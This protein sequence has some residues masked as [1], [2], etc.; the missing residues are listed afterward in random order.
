MNEISKKFDEEQI[1][2]FKNIIDTK[3]DNLI[4]FSQKLSKKEIDIMNSNIENIFK[5]INSGISDFDKKK[6]F[7]QNNIEYSSIIKKHIIID[8]LKNP[9]KI[10]N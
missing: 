4:I 2:G 6:N 8:K 10:K 7:I 5:P 3:K 9:D 1:E